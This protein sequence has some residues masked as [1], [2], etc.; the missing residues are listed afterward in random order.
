M[1]GSDIF[2]VGDGAEETAR[3]P[4]AASLDAAPDPWDQFARF[5]AEDSFTVAWLTA[6]SRVHG[7]R[8]PAVGHAEG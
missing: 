4:D 2:I 7:W 8:T 3:P 5:E 6:T 1:R